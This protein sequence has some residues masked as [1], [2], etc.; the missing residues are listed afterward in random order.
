M[1]QQSQSV[2]TFIYG[3]DGRRGRDLVRKESA[4]GNLKAERTKKAREGEMW[5]AFVLLSYVF[6]RQAMVPVGYKTT[7][8]AELV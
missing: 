1:S 2:N 8:S 7:L 5:V 6:R 4:R 3:R